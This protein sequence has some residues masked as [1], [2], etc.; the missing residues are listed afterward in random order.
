MRQLTLAVP[1]LA[2][3]LLAGCVPTTPDVPS[4]S[5]DVTPTPT[6]TETSAPSPTPT[7]SGTP[8]TLSCDELVSAQVMYDYN[9]N[10]ALE[11][12]FDPAPGSLAAEAVAAQGLACRW[13][14]QSSGETID[15]AV[16]NLP[17]EALEA[18]ANE[19]VT[20]SNSVPT[21]GVEG[22]FRVVD[23]AGEAQAFS[24]PFWVSAVGAGFA[25]PGDPAPL[26]IAALA[27]LG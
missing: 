20:T 1:V 3:L 24:A 14:N 22:Y 13:V 11:G 10:V 5:P 21:Y 6:A 25:E 15:I 4:S 27:A 19:L 16:A 18:R 12:T 8:I 17:T 2:L 23:G 9:S 26:V 7:A